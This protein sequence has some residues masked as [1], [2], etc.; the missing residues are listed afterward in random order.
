MSPE[1]IAYTASSVKNSCPSWTMNIE[2]EVCMGMG[3]T[4]IDPMGPMGMGITVTLSWE[5]E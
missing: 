4:G 1:D 3:L 5:W 2:L